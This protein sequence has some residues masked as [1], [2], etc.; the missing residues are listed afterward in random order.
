MKIAIDCRMSGKSGIGTFL[1][2]IL[3]FLNTAQNELLLIGSDSVPQ[4]LPFP[5]HCTALRCAI[6]MFSIRELF[7]FP[8]ELLSSIN[9]C[10]VYFSPYCNIPGGITIPIYSTIHDI[11]FLDMEHIAGKAGTFVRKQFYKRA[12]RLSTSLFTV[13]EFSKGRIQEK[14][15]CTKPIFVVYNGTPHYLE[16][17]LSPVPQKND[18]I[19]FV[20]NIKAHKGLRTLIEAFVLFYQSFEASSSKP[21]LLIVG[22]QENF[23]TKDQSLSNY[24][25]D[26]SSYGIEFTGHVTDEKLHVL[27]AQARFLVQPSLYE[28][29]GIPPLEALYSGT[30]AL[31]SDIPVFKE[32]YRELPV[33]FFACG[34]SNDLASKM[35]L[36]W[37]MKKAP[38]INKNLYTYERTAS[39]IKNT[40]SSHS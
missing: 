32:I 16:Q 36:L 7:F 2:G 21:K 25:Q 38:V 37:N 13:S 40:L 24:L 18:S 17:R 23:R 5:T 33:T 35:H 30:N 39:L 28:G 8:K 27:L 31:I 1:D 14:L 20:G 4:S 3:P 19:I 6:K 26:S 12:I 10:D 11:V 34:D 22:S 15:H 29:F 9:K